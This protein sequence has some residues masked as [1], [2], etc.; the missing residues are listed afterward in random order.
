MTVILNSK[1]L[2]EEWNKIMFNLISK[3]LLKEICFLSNGEYT[4]IFL[5]ILTQLYI[6][7]FFILIGPPT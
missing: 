2:Y 1:I 5:S 7:L 4:Y 3:N 6:K